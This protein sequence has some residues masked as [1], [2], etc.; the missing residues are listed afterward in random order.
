VNMKDNSGNTPLH[1]ALMNKHF[2]IAQILVENGSSISMMNNEGH[3]PLHYAPP[4]LQQQ[5]QE[6]A[7]H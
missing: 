1:V 5:L 3:P 6:M 2:K 7:C 4:K